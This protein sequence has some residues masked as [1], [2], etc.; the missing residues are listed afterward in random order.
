MLD[1]WGL[2]YS[3]RDQIQP[4]RVEEHT[5][6]WT[7]DEAQRIQEEF[8]RGR[9]NVLSCSTTFEMGVDV[10]AVQAVLC[11]NVPPTPA[12]YIQRAGRAGRREGDASLVVTLART[13]SHDAYYSSQPERL[14]SGVV[15][16]PSIDINNADLARRHLY[17]TAL[18][19]FL[20]ETFPNQPGG[21][22]SGEFFEADGGRSG[23]PSPAARFATWATG[24]GLLSVPA[25]DIGFT[26]S[27]E[28]ELGVPAPGG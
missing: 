9:I 14:V 15:P 3:N 17:A 7:S 10:G 26:D 6:Q 4:L 11:R 20:S 2:L 18:S 23:E 12:N 16:V 1:Y 25:T 8:V 21:L 24:P 5:A 22:S 13:R 28:R 27:V 19:Q